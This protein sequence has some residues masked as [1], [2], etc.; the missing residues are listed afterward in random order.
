MEIAWEMK[1]EVQ[2]M[3]VMVGVLAVMLVGVGPVMGQGGLNYEDGLHQ[4]RSES[5]GRD[6]DEGLRQGRSTERAF[7][8][9]DRKREEKEKQKVQ[10]DKDRQLK[11]AQEAAEEAAT[12]ARRESAYRQGKAA[13]RKKVNRIRKSAGSKPH[14]SWQ[15]R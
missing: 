13:Q 8:E 14:N 12:D 6:Y 15:L 4:G 11:A 2:A 9:L 3:K 5:V 10:E 7:Q 1:K